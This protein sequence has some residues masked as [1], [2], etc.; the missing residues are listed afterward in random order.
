MSRELYRLGEREALLTERL[1]AETDAERKESLFSQLAGVDA[2]RAQ[3]FD[4][5]ADLE[6]KRLRNSIAAIVAGGKVNFPAEEI[7]KMI[8]A[9]KAE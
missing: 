9:G 1:S 4:Q 2:R 6:D 5:C 7:R 8:A 3:M